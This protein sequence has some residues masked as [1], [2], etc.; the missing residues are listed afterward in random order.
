MSQGLLQQAAYIF[1]I[2]CSGH[3]VNYKI[4]G[5]L[6]M[7]TTTF[8]SSPAAGT[9]GHA[10][11][12]CMTRAA[13]GRW[14]RLRHRL[15][16]GGLSPAARRRRNHQGGFC[17]LS[18]ACAAAPLVGGPKRHLAGGGCALACPRPAGGGQGRPLA[19]VYLDPCRAPPAVVWGA[20]NRLGWPAVP[21]HPPPRR[22]RRADPRKAGADAG[23]GERGREQWPAIPFMF[24]V[25]GRIARPS[26]EQPLFRWGP[27]AAPHRKR[28]H[29][30]ARRFGARAVPRKAGRDEP[31]GPLHQGGLPGGALRAG[32]KAA[33]A[34]SCWW[35]QFVY[36]FLYRRR[37]DRDLIQH[38]LREICH[39][40]EIVHHLFQQ[41]IRHPCPPFL[42]FLRIQKERSCIG[43][44]GTGLLPFFCRPL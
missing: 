32:A 17:S 22:G 21:K 37:G 31:K 28:P 44:L 29:T 5:S 13:Q 1:M 6:V 39:N 19:A 33:A 20:G 38:L 18:G 16:G 25:A 8:P 15:H 11:R 14:R 3:S 35:A 23:L 12:A 36:G 9:G 24:R 40:I 4:L 41:V 34:L 7:V 10:S 43:E 27:F 2:A 42:G 26:T 30:M